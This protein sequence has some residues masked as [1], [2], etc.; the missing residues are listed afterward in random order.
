M[1][2]RVTDTAGHPHIHSRPHRDFPTIWSGLARFFFSEAAIWARLVNFRT[3][4]PLK[5]SH[6]WLSRAKTPLLMRVMLSLTCPSFGRCYRHLMNRAL[7]TNGSNALQDRRQA[8][9]YPVALAVTLSMAVGVTHNVSESGV[10]FESGVAVAVD[11]SIHFTLIFRAMRPSAPIRI[12]C[13]GHVVRV[14][15]R[16]SQRL[17][18]VH[19]DDYRIDAECF[20][21]GGHFKGNRQRAR[22][23]V[24][25]AQAHSGFRDDRIVPSPS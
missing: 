10:L 17:V 23:V 11:E 2:S 18:A 13:S 1:R 12:R 25:S 3:H 24:G 5:P 19:L 14:E 22:R 9:R 20:N 7:R 6:R 15:R 4:S 21:L 8:E 16:G